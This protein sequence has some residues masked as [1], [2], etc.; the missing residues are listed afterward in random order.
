VSL[1]T[2]LFPQTHGVEPVADAQSVDGV[3]KGV[4]LSERAQT[5]PELFAEAGYDTRMFT[6][7]PNASGVYGLAQGVEDYQ[8]VRGDGTDLTALVTENLSRRDDRP[9]FAY[10]HYRRPHPPLDAGPES[11]KARW[12]AADLRR[13]VAMYHA[14]IR[15][16]DEAVGRLLEALDLEDTL[17]VLLSDHGEAMGEHRWLG[18]NWQSYEEYVHVPLMIAGPSVP[19]GSVITSPVMTIDVLPTLVEWFGLATPS[20]APQGR[21]LAGPVAGRPPAPRLVFTASRQDVHGKRQLAVSDGRYKLLRVL[22]EGREWLFD[23][24]SDPAETEDLRASTK[25]TAE[26]L[27][28][29]LEDWYG[30]Q[31]PL[32]DQEGVELDDATLERLRALGYVIDGR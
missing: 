25:D 31:S 6:Q 28:R 12:K 17:V 19:A 20:P 15:H 13:H 2:G 7:N 23:L 29:T 1:F 24:A 9:M 4:R 26:R 27:G 18:H 16:V 8:E 5:L 14:N 32:L 22:P 10:V 21:S 3:V 11:G 30:G